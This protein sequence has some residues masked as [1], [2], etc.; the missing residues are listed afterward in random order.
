[1]TQTDAEIVDP[2]APLPGASAP[3]VGLDVLELTGLRDDPG[4]FANAVN[5]LANEINRLFGLP[6]AEREDIARSATNFALQQRGIPLHIGHDGVVHL[7]NDATGGSMLARLLME[8]NR[9]GSLDPA[10]YSSLPNLPSPD[11]LVTAGY[12]EPFIESYEA[13]VNDIRGDAGMAAAT[14]LGSAFMITGARIGSGSI[15]HLQGEGT[16]YTGARQD[17]LPGTA[18]G[19]QQ[20][21]LEYNP[22]TQT[23]ERVVVPPQGGALATQPGGP[24]V[25]PAPQGGS[26]NLAQQ[27]SGIFP[28]TTWQQQAGRMLPTTGE[29]AGALASQQP[30]GTVTSGRARPPGRPGCL[31]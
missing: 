15:P 16:V 28:G 5:R 30:G 20:I 18:E 12:S 4:F 13:S 14:G 29:D 17:Q 6:T 27:A 24:V 22:Q 25:A 10:G 8:L 19:R 23:F 3:T 1:M 21:R 26:T 11:S 9:P 7:P 2:N 31:G